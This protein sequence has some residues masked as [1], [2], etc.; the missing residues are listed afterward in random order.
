MEL[1]FHYNTALPFSAAVERAELSA[2]ITLKCERFWKA[3]NCYCCNVYRIRIV[4]LFGFNTKMND[5][6]LNTHHGALG[7]ML[8]ID[9]GFLV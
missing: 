5:F 2:V 4:L 7:Y 3:I 1:F 8:R 9:G 6:G